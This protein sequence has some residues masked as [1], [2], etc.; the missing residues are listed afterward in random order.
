MMK[1]DLNFVISARL[2]EAIDATGGGASSFG[3]RSRAR[4]SRARRATFARA[5]EPQRLRAHVSRDV[6]AHA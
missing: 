2:L 1:A 4:V 3:G 5:R 6:C